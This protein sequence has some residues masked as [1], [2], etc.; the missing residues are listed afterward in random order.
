MT[1]L[2]LLLCAVQS[3]C[4]SP[5]Y[6]CLLENVGLIH[7]RL[8]LLSIINEVV[9]LNKLVVVVCIVYLLRSY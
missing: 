7:E 2:W 9:V 1:V 6:L 3:C 5:V 8:Y 4:G